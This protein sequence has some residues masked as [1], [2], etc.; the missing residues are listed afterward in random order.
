MMRTNAVKWMGIATNEAATPTMSNSELLLPLMLLSL[1]ISQSAVSHSLAKLRVLF[2]DPLFVRT[3]D[4]MQPTLLADRLAE[5]FAERMHE[6]VRTE[7]CGYAADESFTPIEL[8]KESFQGIR[9]APGYPSQPDHTEKL[10]LFDLLD[11]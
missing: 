4:G 10:A 11:A 7:L 1:F 3:P 8:L 2:G 9:P 6:R 5:A